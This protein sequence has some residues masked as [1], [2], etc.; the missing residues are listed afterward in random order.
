MLVGVLEHEC[1]ELNNRFYTY[2]NKQRPYILLKWATSS[3]GFFDVNRGILSVDDA[4]PT[5]IT[6][7]YSQQL[8]HQFRAAEHAILVGTETVLKDNP[9]LDVRHVAG[10]NPIRIV[11]DKSLRIPLRYHIFNGKCKTIIITDC[12]TEVINDYLSVANLI[13]ERIDFSKSIVDE[14]NKV[15]YLNEIQSVL[16][17]GGKQLIE[18]F[19]KTNIWDEAKVF[20][21]ETALKSGIKSPLINTNPY[22]SQFVM[23]DLLSFYKNQNIL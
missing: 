12:K 13:I 8:V 2:H 19:L 22:K 11:L 5:W 14:I 20:T 6:N 16:I 15:L 1:L 4:K 3:D 18:S 10:N 7:K 21:G 9:R 23:G 17:E